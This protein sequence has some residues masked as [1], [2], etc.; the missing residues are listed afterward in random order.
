MCRSIKILRLPYAA[1]VTD[2]DLH[3]AAL[4]YVQTVSGFRVP[5]TVAAD[6]FY[7]AVETVA[8]VTADLLTVIEASVG[9]AQAAP[10]GIVLGCPRGRPRAGAVTAGPWS[11]RA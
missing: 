7:R 9:E 2:D 11:A 4:Q 6:A 5:P 3:A 1:S 10:D 8:A